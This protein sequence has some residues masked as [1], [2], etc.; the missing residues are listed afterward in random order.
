MV[1]AKGEVRPALLENILAQPDAIRGVAAHQFGPGRPALMRSAEMLRTS[2][3]IVLSGMGASLFAS[4]PLSYMLGRRGVAVSV[5][6]TSELLYFLCPTLDADTAVVLVS[7]SGESV[8]ITKLLPILKQRGCR[9]IGVV[10]V[11]DSTL[12]RQ[13][14]HTIFVNSAPD[15]LVAIQTYSGTLATLALLGAAYLD[16]LDSTKDELRKTVTL[17][18]SRLPGCLESTALWGGLLNRGSRVY[19]LGRGAALASVSAGVLLMHEVAKIPVVGMSSAQFRHGPVEV[20]DENFQAVVFTSQLAT[21]ELDHALAEDLTR[22]GGDIRRIGSYVRRSRIASLCVWPDDFPCRFVSILEI[23][24]L[25]L[26][27]YQIAVAR[28]VPTGQFRFAP[29]V[30]RSET[31]FSV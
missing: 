20:V 10:N 22:I 26:L 31:G 18:A 17:L 4:I 27:A 5:I 28:G 12:A 3:R 7:R 14:D 1:R 15:E 29:A 19:L 9:V 30:T 16:E 2:K 23:V 6:E 25:Q 8:E 24:P 21:A 11:A 13:A